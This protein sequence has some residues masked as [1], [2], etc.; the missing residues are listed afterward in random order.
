MVPALVTARAAGAGERYPRP[1]ES[2]VD[3]DVAPHYDRVRDYD[4]LHTAVDL[5]FDWDHRGVAGRVT[6]RLTPFRDDT[7]EL[8]FDQHGMDF[9]A[10]TLASGKELKW[11]TT[12]DTLTVVLDRPY[13]RGEE[14]EVTITYSVKDIPT[15][16]FFIEPTDAYPKRPW[17]VWTQGESEDTHFWVPCYD[18]P[19][20][21]M[22]SDE[23]FTVERRFS[24]VAN[25]T[26]EG[27]ADNDD[28]TRTWHFLQVDADYPPYLMA[29]AV[30][31]YQI[32]KE[33]A[34]G[35]PVESYVRPSLFPHAE[36]SFGTTGDM[37]D[38]FTSLFGPYPYE[39]Y[40]QVEVAEF[41][42]G[43][44][45]NVTATILTSRTLHDEI[46][47]EV[48][49]S[50]GLVAHEL[51][52]MWWGDH[53][54]ARNWANIW[55]AEGFATYAETLYWEHAEG[56]Q[57]GRW[58]NY[59]NQVSYFT[60]D[61]A[62]RRPLVTRYYDSY[63]DLFDSV[64]YS[65]GS[66][67]LHM[68]RRELGD[69][70][71]FDVLQA[72]QSGYG[73]TTVETSDFERVVEQVSGRSLDRFFDQWVYH[74]GHP[75]LH[76]SWSY[77]PANKLVH[78][79]V[80]QTQEVTELT[81][82]FDVPVTI[83]LTGE[84]FSRRVEIRV[85]KSE[86]DFYL[87]AP[88]RPDMVEF[89]REGWTLARTTFEKPVEE[90]VYQIRN[91]P[92][93]VSRARAAEALGEAGDDDAVAALAE[94]LANEDEFWGV[95][96][97]AAKAL[98]VAGGDD[99]RRALIRALSLD[100]ARVREEAAHALAGFDDD[101]EAAAALEATARNDRS[102]QVT[103]AALNSLGKVKAPHGV[104]TVRAA[105]RRDSWQDDVRVGALE[106][107]GPLADEDGIDVAMGYLGDPWGWR[108]RQAAIGALGAMGGE[109]EH[110]DPRVDKIRKTCEKTLHDD[111]IQVR[112]TAARA[113][114]KLG[115]GKARGALE[116]ASK[117][118]DYL[119][120]TD[121]CRDALEKLRDAETREES[122]EDL[123][124]QVANLND[125]NKGLEED[126]KRLREEMDTLK[127]GN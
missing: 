68:L 59:R 106:A 41:L 99:A 104:E 20:E 19:N 65:K 114:G 83:D 48:Y 81:P 86:N 87:E 122:A 12:G 50:E 51:A 109:L 97:A 79:S 16:A 117:R 90:W 36:R 49:Q 98:G 77:D 43:G 4:V 95:R 2:F 23:K 34:G 31:E 57:R 70:V 74:G 26:L 7:R 125:R 53:V 101:R 108:V 32:Y 80:R 105:L 93:C 76:V 13:A 96:E 127:R 40:R 18:N 1:T 84:G 22:T 92:E 9:S 110:D 119:G 72:F 29:F 66:N 17:Q 37:L 82:L 42:F 102:Y 38:L 123:K 5:R 112:T 35:I 111:V 24:V 116:K 63:D 21:R 61:R 56:V 55:I 28:G 33:D 60:E 73:G 124:K 10:V 94:V 27:I 64:A 30:G 8:N 58:D 54:S 11:R 89:D 67:V 88:G 45:E 91:S 126:L 62:Y 113:L 100:S 39:V 69:S 75:E 120:F 46:G 78:L 85:S 121:A 115:S 15:G 118:D 3:G 71:F 44:M 107:L 6:H 103:V 52:H 14:L 47:H 25:G